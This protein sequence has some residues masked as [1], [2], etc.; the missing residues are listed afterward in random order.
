MGSRWEGD[1]FLSRCE[2]NPPF[3]PTENS[4]FLFRS[5]FPFYIF[6]HAFFCLVLC[7]FSGFGAATLFETVTAKGQEQRQFT[8]C[9]YWSLGWIFLVNTLF[10]GVFLFSFSFQFALSSFE[11]REKTKGKRQMG[12]GVKNRKTKSRSTRIVKSW[13]FCLCLL[14]SIFGWTVSVKPVG[15]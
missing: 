13:Y 2:W 15:R 12:P 6:R 3:C 7:S 14:C 8:V 5:F 10:P 11:N 1:N 9:L 4:L